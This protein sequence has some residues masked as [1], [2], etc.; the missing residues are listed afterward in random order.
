MHQLNAPDD[1]ELA[2]DILGLLTAAAGPLSVRDLVALRSDRQETPSAA[3]MLQ[4][5]RLVEEHAARSLEH[6]GPADNERYQF[7][8]SSLLEYAQTARDLRDPEYRQRIHH[9]ARHWRDAGWPTPAG[10]DKGTPQYL[11]DTYP[12]TLTQDPQQLAQLAGDIGWVEAAI[13]S[14]GVDPVLANL[15]LALAANPTSTV[16]A[17][18]LAAVT[19]Q[20]HNL[21]PPQPLDQPGYILRQ[22]WM[23]AA[24]LAEDDLADYIHSR[25]QSQPGSCLVPRCTTRRTSRS[26]SG[27]L[28]RHV[29][30]VDAIAAL[31]DGRVVTSGDNRVLVWDPT[32]P[33][34]APAELGRQIGVDA[35]AALAD[36]RVV[37]AG[38]GGR[39]LVW[40]LA[41]P[42][43]DPAELGIHDG[44][45]RAVAV[46]A[47][48]RVVTSGDDQQV[49]VWD[50]A[51]PGPAR[52]G[53]AAAAGMC[54][55]WRCWPTGVW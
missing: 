10:E 43:A 26:L 34:T 18:A 42:G 39:L 40:D 12:A 45:V 16:V 32:H 23:Q 46:L 13:A 19:G 1:P 5:R 55:R 8:H 52:P 7:A 20:N 9:W 14:A 4:V 2:V 50:L 28:G 6:V 38:Y 22:L 54:R 27:E 29:Y 44:G 48:R 11:L 36:G 41:A 37:T 25:L 35:I 53:W 24:E 31:A 3:D 30:S 17:A 49:L 15:R 47:N 51:A 33:G 21:R